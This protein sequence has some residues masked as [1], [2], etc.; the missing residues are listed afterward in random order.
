MPMR[1]R[2]LTE[3]IDLLSKLPDGPECIQRGE[4][5]IAAIP[6]AGVKSL[7]KGWASP[8]AG[9][10]IHARR[11]S[12]VNGWSGPPELFPALFGIAG[13]HLFESRVTEGLPALRDSSFG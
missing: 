11:G 2:N 13:I 10:R 4:L 8:D 7:R 3:A 6:R 5:V 9:A 1:F 12:F